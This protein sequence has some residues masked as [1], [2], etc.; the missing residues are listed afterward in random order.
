MDPI[1]SPYRASREQL[2]CAVHHNDALTREGALERMFTYLFSGL[3]YPQI[4]EDPVVD[5]DALCLRRTDHVVAIASGGCNVASYLVAQPASITAVDLNAAHIALN[6]M[7]LA[8]IQ[9]APDHSAL[10]RFFGDAAD[11]R[12]IEMYEQY[13][14]PHLDAESRTYWEDGSLL[15]EKRIAQFGKGFYRHGLLGC[16]IGAVHF[17][18]RAHGYNLH[19]VLEARTI[20]EQRQAYEIH[21]AP[22]FD[23]PVIK[24][25]AGQPAS[26]YGLGIPPAQYRTLARDHEEGMIGALRARVEKLAY[27]FPLD[28]NYFSWQAFGR[29]YSKRS[30]GPLPPYLQAANFETIRANAERVRILHESMTTHLSSLPAASADCFVLLDAQDWMNDRDLNALWTQISRTAKP[31]ARVIFRTAADEPLLPGRLHPDTLDL[32]RKDE[33]RS[34]A[35]HA[36]D[37]SAI[38]GGFHLYYLNRVS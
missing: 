16:F 19:R 14:A 1:T 24:W 17:L 11:K 12:N 2:A 35:L 26:L 37:R 13:I 20:E 15:R 10:L 6:K 32:W 4:W 5:M 9:H 7:K 18:A 31:G 29:S 3:V 8:A 23:K 30:E 38:Y 25:L 34:A 27:G 28:D 22:L 33:A 21:V 36:R